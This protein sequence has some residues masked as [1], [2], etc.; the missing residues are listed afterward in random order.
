LAAMPTLDRLAR[1]EQLGLLSSAEDWLV[2]R[3][4]QNQFTQ[5]YPD[6]VNKRFER[7]Q[8]AVNAA[9]QLITVMAQLDGKLRQRFSDSDL[10]QSTPMQA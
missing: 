6:A 5:E 9:Y 8:D 2:L 4:I 1:L 7:L 10:L 3:Q